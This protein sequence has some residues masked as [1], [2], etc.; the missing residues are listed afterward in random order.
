METAFVF[1][2]F[3][4]RLLGRAGITDAPAE[5]L[6]LL[7]TSAGIVTLLFAPFHP[8]LW[9]KLTMLAVA[10]MVVLLAATG[11][12]WDCEDA[13]QNCHRGSERTLHAG[14]LIVADH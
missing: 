4:A 5:C 7:L 10:W 6:A 9:I 2:Y 1:P 11:C 12:I 8:R 3:L 13:R 14:T